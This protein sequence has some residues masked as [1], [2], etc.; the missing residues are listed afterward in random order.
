MVV[1]SKLSKVVNLHI[2]ITVVVSSEIE[3]I[4]YVERF[5]E[6]TIVDKMD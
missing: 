5:P 4:Y 3:E 6:V 2:L 1:V